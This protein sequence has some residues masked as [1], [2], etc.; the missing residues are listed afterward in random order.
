MA[1]FLIAEANRYPKFVEAHACIS[2][3]MNELASE[4]AFTQYNRGRNIE[5]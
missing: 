1:Y 3:K 2:H 5:V 4:L